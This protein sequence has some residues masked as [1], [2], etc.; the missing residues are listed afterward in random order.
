MPEL[1]KRFAAYYRPHRKLFVLDFGYR[2]N[3]ERMNGRPLVL[4]H[5]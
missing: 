3:V 2:M 5:L 1:L 4:H